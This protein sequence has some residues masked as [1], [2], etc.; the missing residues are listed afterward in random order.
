[1]IGITKQYKDTL[2]ITIQHIETLTSFNEVIHH[3]LNVIVSSTHHSKRRESSAPVVVNPLPRRVSAP[4][5]VTDYFEAKKP[6]T[7]LDLLLQENS[8]EEEPLTQQQ[9][10]VLRVIQQMGN[11][12]AEGVSM[13]MILQNAPKLR[14]SQKDIVYS[15]LVALSKAPRCISCLAKDMRII[16]SIVRT[17]NP[18]TCFAFVCATH[19]SAACFS[20]LTIISL[21]LVR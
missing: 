16:Q 3:W 18:P 13:Q 8:W 15:I 10:S 2:C 21:F 12:S 4:S 17:S 5:Q 19:F 6:K 14:M 20:K 11:S 9:Q 7:S 1:M